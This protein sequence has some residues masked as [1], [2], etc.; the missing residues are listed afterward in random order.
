[1]ERKFLLGLGRGAAFQ[2]ETFF[3]MLLIK[4]D[5]AMNS[6]FTS[7][8]WEGKWHSLLLNR[9]NKGNLSFDLQ[10]FW[11]T[12]G[13]I[14]FPQK[15]ERRIIKADSSFYHR[16]HGVRMELEKPGK[17]SSRRLLRLSAESSCR[18]WLWLSPPWPPPP[19]QSPMSVVTKSLGW[20]KK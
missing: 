14:L 20:Q 8:C 2:R 9:Q 3:E 16:L 6:Y 12:R 18:E 1:M 7:Q 19:F 10:A 11:Q 15:V 13:P 17:V 5:Q 4:S